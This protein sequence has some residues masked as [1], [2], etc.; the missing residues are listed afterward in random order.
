MRDICF[1]SILFIVLF[2]CNEK[3][4]SEGELAVINLLPSDS[5]IRSFFSLVDTVFIIP[6]ETTDEALI[7]NISGLRVSEEKIV[8][9][10]VLPTNTEVLVFNMLGEYMFK[11]SK[12]GRG[13]GEYLSINCADIKPNTENLVIVDGSTRSIIEYSP[14]SEVIQS[15]KIGS[16]ITSTQTIQTSKGLQYIISSGE[17]LSDS[18]YSYSLFRTHENGKLLEKMLPFEYTSRMTT[19]STQ[20]LFKVSERLVSFNREFSNYIYYITDSVIF[21]KYYLDFPKQILPAEKSNINFLKNNN[22]EVANYVFNIVIQES[23]DLISCRYL[24]NWK[25]FWFFYHKPSNHS[26][27]VSPPVNNGCKSCGYLISSELLWQDYLLFPIK[28]DELISAIE[29]FRQ[30][31]FGYLSPPTLSSGW[32]ISGNP[33]LFFVKLKVEHENK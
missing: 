31:G 17:R 8:V 7:T 14:K 12:M 22:P 33:V 26:I 2:S 4:E 23:K 6:L 15:F 9:I 5:N 30:N 21:K 10:N 11:L 25:L 19:G 27:Q 1:V 18:D 28:S 32:N 3:A 16:V 13:P 24:L 29:E 20:R